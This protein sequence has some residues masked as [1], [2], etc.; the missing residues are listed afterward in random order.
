[1]YIGAPARFCQ[2]CKDEKLTLINHILLLPPPIFSFFRW[3]TTA[4]QRVFT[5]VLRMKNVHSLNGLP[6]RRA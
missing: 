3:C 1:M 5:D 4:R 6:K 2:R